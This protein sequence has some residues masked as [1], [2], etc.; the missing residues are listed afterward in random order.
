MI[1]PMKPSRLQNFTFFLRQVGEFFAAAFAE[2]EHGFQ[3]ERFR[4]GFLVELHV[5]H[6]LVDH[7][8]GDRPFERAAQFAAEKFTPMKKHRPGKFVKKF[9]IGNL[10][11]PFFV[12]NDP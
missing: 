7:F 4:P 3:V 8:F 1:S 12:V 2:A 9:Q 5:E 6:D 10:V 11:L